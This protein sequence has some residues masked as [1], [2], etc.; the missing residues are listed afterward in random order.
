MRRLVLVCLA[1]A[2]AFVAVGCTSSSGDDIGGDDVALITANW[3][4]KELATNTINTTCPNGFDTAAV[5]AHRV[6]A[7]QADIIDLYDCNAGTGTPLDADGYP[8][9]DYDVFV[10]IEDTNGANVFAKSLTSE[11]DVT[12]ADKTFSTTIIEDGGYFFFTYDLV[13]AANNSPLTCAQAGSPDAI[14]IT[15]TVTGGTTAFSDQF[16]CSDTDPT[17]LTAGLLAG[18]YTTSVSANNAAGQALGAPANSANEVVAD[19]NEVTDL[20][21]ITLPID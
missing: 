10:Q 16:D 19:R 17:G 2:A 14:E 7:T 15:S 6:D 9:G 1:T 4:F 5:V 8:P 20:G 12:T 13:D 21:T 3:D 18:S 11:V